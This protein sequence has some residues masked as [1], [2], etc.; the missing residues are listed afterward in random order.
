MPPDSAAEVADVLVEC[1]GNVLAAGEELVGGAGGQEAALAKAQEAPEALAKARQGALAPG[2]VAAEA[3]AVVSV[4]V[5]VGDLDGDFDGGAGGLAGVLVA[6]GMGDTCDELVLDGAGIGVGDVVGGDGL[7][8]GI[9]V[10]RAVVERV[11]G[12]VGAGVD[13]VGGPGAVGQVAAELAMR[14][15]RQGWS[16]RVSNSSWY[17]ALRA[18]WRARNS[19][20]SSSSHSG[21]PRASDGSSGS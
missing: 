17:L 21:W 14:S 1:A 7:Q 15:S 10:V 12:V 4:A 20:Q 18:S 8:A 3:V 11:V 5:A 2:D 6:V 13:L 16:A 9:G 19:S